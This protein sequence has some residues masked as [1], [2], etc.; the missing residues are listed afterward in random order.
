MW[1]AHSMATLRRWGCIGMILVPTCRR[2]SREVSQQLPA[3]WQRRVGQWG[4]G[5]PAWMDL[6]AGIASL[7]SQGLC[8]HCQQ[9]PQSYSETSLLWG[10]EGMSESG[11]DRE[12]GM[13]RY[14]MREK[15]REIQQGRTGRELRP[16]L[17]PQSLLPQALEYRKS[18][19][20]TRA[21][22][23][24]LAGLV[25]P[26]IQTDNALTRYLNAQLC[27]TSTLE[28]RLCI[29]LF[30]MNFFFILTNLLKLDSI[31][32]VKWHVPIKALVWCS[33]CVSKRTTKV[34]NVT[35]C[36]HW[37]R[38]RIII[39]E[40]VELLVLKDGHAS[41]YLQENS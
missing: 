15:K 10:W 6:T 26:C 20:Q 29:T 40:Y 3:A 36:S 34:Y 27:D 2:K 18:K 32:M 7:A 12:R 37:Y 14:S 9:S 25:L 21:E 30:S 35:S 24:H 39:A 33:E 16:T 28:H 11:G 22:H 17:L 5:Q 8:T 23:W 13:K 19:E 41:R 38:E 31:S 1:C 4:R